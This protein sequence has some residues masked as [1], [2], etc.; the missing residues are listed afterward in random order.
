M[1][2]FRQIALSCTGEEAALA[3]ELL[4]VCGAQAV[5]LT[6]QSDS[7]IFEPPLGTHPVWPTTCLLALFHDT[8]EDREILDELALA[9]R[10]AGCAIELPT[11]LSKLPDQDWVRTALDQFQPTQI[12]N[13]WV[14][15][16]W[17]D[18][19][20]PNAC[21]P[22]KLDPGLAFGTGMHPTTQLCLEWLSEYP[23]TDMEVLDFGC[24]SGILGIAA[25]CQ[26][27]ACVHGIDI[28]NQALQATQS[29][30]ALNALT[31]TTVLPEAAPEHNYDLVLANVLANPLIELADT[32]ISALRPGGTLVMA[33]LLDTQAKAVKAAYPSLE[34]SPDVSKSGW[35]RLVGHKR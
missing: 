13:F 21:I 31:V 35:T 14:T 33:G 6:D 7:P 4:F 18:S 8:R 3:E 22:L 25:G 16:S 29:N 34:F 10:R 23:A 20:P 27:A 15:P 30:A 11:A 12:G 19:A 17:H 32:L 24:G 1:T 2:D 9:F 28:D 26:G 5:S